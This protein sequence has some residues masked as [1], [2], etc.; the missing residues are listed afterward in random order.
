[1][2][3]KT[4]LKSNHY[5]LMAI[6]PK[7][8]SLK[9]LKLYINEAVSFGKDG[10]NYLT[11]AFN[12]FHKNGGKLEKFQMSNFT[13]WSGVEMYSYLK[14]LPDLEI[15]N[16]KNNSLQILQAKALGKV[17]SDFKNIKEIDLSNACITTQLGK[18]IADGL[19]RAKQLE[20]FR[21]RDVS[22]LD[23]S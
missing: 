17:L 7:L 4:N 10:H 9:S 11:K 22:S 3:C 20:V 15:L 18:E 16:F 21:M 2:I 14:S 5:W 6:I 8:T 1:M 12:Y 13:D 23:P 19:M